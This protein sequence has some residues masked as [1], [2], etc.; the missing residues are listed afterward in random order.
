VLI[1]HGSASAS[2][3]FAAAI[4]DLHRGVI[5]GERSFGKGTVQNLIDLDAAV[6]TSGGGS[7][8]ELKMTIAEF[9]RLNGVS[10]QF[11]GVAPDIAFPATG[12]ERLFGENT[13]ENALPASTIAPVPLAGTAAPG[14]M[15]RLLAG[16]DKRVAQSALWKLTLDEIA[17][18]QR[19]GDEKSVSL[20][21]EER[22]AARATKK[23]L[24]GSFEARLRSIQRAHGDPAN[25]PDAFS[26]DDGLNPS[27][28][29]LAEAPKPGAHK[30]T[31]TDAYLLEAANIVADDFA[32]TAAPAQDGTDTTR[33]KKKQA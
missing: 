31:D 22:K 30:A 13:Y 15:A 4:Q 7:L 20:N 19:E 18:G 24:F 23:A 10:T 27:E 21:F 1:N 5:M 11:L 17:E 8:G 9:Y 6:G 28:R 26:L 25:D 32:L 3:I 2:E 33:T 12:D 16:H 29:D 14:V